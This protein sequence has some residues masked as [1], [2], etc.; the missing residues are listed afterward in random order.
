MLTTANP[1]YDRKFRLWRQHGMSVSDTVRH[2][3][4]DVIYE[5]YPELGYNYRM[6]DLQAA[7]GRE[8]L[9]RLP[10]IVA[11]RRQLAAQYSDQLA[12]IPGLETPIEP[13]WARS[14]W[15]SYCVR[16]PASADQ[17]SVMQALLD[18]GISTRRGVMNIHLEPA[19]ADQA[20]SRRASSLDRSVA[21]QNKT[22]I[23]P[24]FVQM[25][26][27]DVSF[28]TDTLADVLRTA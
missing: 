12:R 5:T 6:T 20:C 13:H 14:N 16:L 18:R 8:Q 25:S 9:R 17:R 22:I 26:E 4:R 23:L 24:L 21:A 1:D 19:Y 2:G 11:R 27:A 3:S 15:Q 10:E 28:V 7:I